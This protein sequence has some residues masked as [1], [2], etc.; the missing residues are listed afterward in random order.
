MEHLAKAFLRPVDMVK[1][2]KNEV[3]VG[4]MPTCHALKESSAGLQTKIPISRVMDVRSG[5][6]MNAAVLARPPITESKRPI[7]AYDRVASSYHLPP[8]IKRNAVRSVFKPPEI[9]TVRIVEPED[10]SMS[11]SRFEEISK[12]AEIAKQTRMTLSKTDD[13][14]QIKK[15]NKALSDH[16]Q[17]IFKKYYEFKQN[18]QD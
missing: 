2:K 17:A 7:A 11:A 3:M 16:T 9:K 14:L 8:V 15:V 1:A 4:R 6:A 5:P 10:S 13:A 12:K 18:G